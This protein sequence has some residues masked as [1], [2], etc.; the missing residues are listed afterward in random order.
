MNKE[1]EEASSIALSKK[2]GPY[3]KF[4]SSERLQIGKYA[5][6]HGAT[7]ASRHFSDKLKKPVC[8]STAKSLKKAY[9]EELRKRRRH[10]D[11]SSVELA[12]LPAK[13]RGR[14]LL[15]GEN[16]DLKV[17]LYLRKVREGGGAVSAR[18][19]VAAARGILRKCNRSML[20]ENGGPIHLTRYWA[21]SLLKRMDF[22]Q[23][24]ATTS[25]RK[26]TMTN[27]KECKRSF[28]N[29]VATTIAMEEIP[30][31]LVLNWDQTGIKLVPS[32]TWT[33]ERKGERRVEMVGVN[34]KRQITAIFCGNAEGDFL[35][36]Q[37]IYT[38]KTP[39]CHPRYVF[40]SEWNVTHSPNHW[41]NEDTMV[42]YVTNIILPYIETVR[43]RLSTESAALVVMDNFKGQATPKIRTTFF[44]LGFL[45][46]QQTDSSQWIYLSISLQ[47]NT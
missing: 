1:V 33:M 47:K 34:D 44:L 46:T 18:I 37:L 23:R 28:L 21:H 31:E 16:L 17:Q 45:Q 12:D 27:F 38:G 11:G 8:R 6:Q 41:S 13:K 9:E 42:Q 29:D 2:R 5:S 39:R 25:L 15:I 24:K 14:K 26:L 30:G 22:V 10:G 3:K 4:S 36:I 35:P 32:S 43:E 7:S 19:A 40:P 20:A